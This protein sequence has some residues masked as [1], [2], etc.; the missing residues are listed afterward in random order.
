MFLQEVGSRRLDYSLF[1]YFE[2]IAVDRKHWRGN[3]KEQQLSEDRTLKVIL[4]TNGMIPAIFGAEG[5]GRPGKG[6]V[7]GKHSR[8]EM[9][10]MAR[11]ALASA[12]D[13]ESCVARVS[14]LWGNRERGVSLRRSRRS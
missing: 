8:N 1:P 13:E 3:G 2:R 6:Q 14:R 9:R 4:S 7:M 10:R 12:F 11:G 5:G